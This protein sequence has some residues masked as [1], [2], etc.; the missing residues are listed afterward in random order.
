MPFLPRAGC[1]W[2]CRTG[3]EEQPWPS[4]GAL[5][6][7]FGKRTASTPAFWSTCVPNLTTWFPKSALLDQ[8]QCP[9]ASLCTQANLRATPGVVWWRCLPISWIPSHPLGCSG[10]GRVRMGRVKRGQEPRHVYL[11]C[12]PC[13]L[14]A[15]LAE[16][17]FPPCFW[18]G[19]EGA[20]W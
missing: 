6:G 18:E 1:V 9:Y 12:W 19:L 3:K 20:P 10:G 2:L 11:G 4:S 16:R 17:L 5:L 8:A 13:E 14:S 7:G 15:R